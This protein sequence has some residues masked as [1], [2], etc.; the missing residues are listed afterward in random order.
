M[1]AEY[2]RLWHGHVDRSPGL[3]HQQSFEFV[4]DQRVAVTGFELRAGLAGRAG[5]GY[6]VFPDRLQC[7]QCTNRILLARTGFGF[8][9]LRA[10]DRQNR[11]LGS[12]GAHRVRMDKANVRFREVRKILD[13]ERVART[14]EYD[15]RGF[16]YDTFLRRGGPVRCDLP[17]L[18]KALNVAFDRKDGN[19]SRSALE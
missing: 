1:L 16:V 7:V 5:S 12:A 18:N 17:A 14:N 9:Q 13:A 11:P 15:E 10:V 3:F 6:D 8:L 2:R 19:I 4:G